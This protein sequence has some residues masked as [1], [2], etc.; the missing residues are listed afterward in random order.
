MSK[1]IYCIKENRLIII[2]EKLGI[3]IDIDFCVS[4]GQIHEVKEYY[5]SDVLKSQRYYLG[6]KL[7]GPSTYFFENGQVATKV[8]YVNGEKQGK[9]FQY[10]KNSRIYS[11]Q[12]YKDNLRLGSHKYFYEDGTLKS[13]FYYENNQLDKKATLFW[14]NGNIKREMNFL[15]G[16]RHGFDKI[17]SYDQRLLFIGEYESDIPIKC[18]KS[19][20]ERGILREETIYKGK[21]YKKSTYD[22][23]GNLIV[24]E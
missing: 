14:E 17:F 11:L 19:Y 12:K 6:K 24:N 21:S 5:P 7:H 13:E 15:K 23:L 16:K 4:E 3:S 10:Y 1:S 18:H 20:D 2:D 9:C 22:H 8:W